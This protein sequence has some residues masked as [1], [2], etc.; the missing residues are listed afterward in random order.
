MKTM[1]MKIMKLYAPMGAR[2]SSENSVEVIIEGSEGIRRGTK[3]EWGS[4]VS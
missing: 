3:N 4:F 2:R 1:P